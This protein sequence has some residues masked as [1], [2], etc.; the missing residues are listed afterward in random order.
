MQGEFFKGNDKQEETSEKKHTQHESI[1]ILICFLVW[2]ERIYIPTYILYICMSV[3]GV[4]RQWSENCIVTTVSHAS[5]M[6][7]SFWRLIELHVRNTHSQRDQKP[8]PDIKKEGKLK[9]N[10]YTKPHTH[11][12]IKQINNNNTTNRRKAIKFH[13]IHRSVWKTNGIFHL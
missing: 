2:K 1:W 3:H 9:S 4:I 5:V 12:R 6:Y 8:M 10:C 7:F 11:E 13:Y